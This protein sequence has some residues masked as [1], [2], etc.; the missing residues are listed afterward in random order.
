MARALDDE[1]SSS[2]GEA[3]SPEQLEKEVMALPA[4]DR[5]RLADQMLASLEPSN[6]GE[7]DLLWAKEAE[8]RLDAFESGIIEAV[9]EVEAHDALEK[10]FQIS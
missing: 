7:I 5:A 1:S 9:S 10:R 2:Y 4:A 8:E 6:Q 3:M